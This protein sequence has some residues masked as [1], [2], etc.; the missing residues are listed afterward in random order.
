MMYA[1]K[2]L[3]SPVSEVEI[4]EMLETLF[5]NPSQDL[6]SDSISESALALSM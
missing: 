6:D 2:S 5:D 3:D 1:N 4:I